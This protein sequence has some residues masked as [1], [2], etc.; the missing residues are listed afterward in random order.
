MSSARTVVLCIDR[1]IVREGVQTLLDA[2]PD[3][4]VVDATDNGMNAIMIVRKLA[5][6]VLVTGVG[7]GAMTGLELMLRIAGERLDTPPAVLMYGTIDDD[8]LL[9]RVLCSGAKGVLADDA[10]PEEMVLAVRLAARG[11]AILGPGAAE[12]V[13]S[14]HRHRNDADV[15]VLAPVDDLLTPREREILV[16]TAR[17]LSIEDIATRL[18]IGIATVRTHLYRLR[19]KLQARDRAQLVTLAFQS[20]LI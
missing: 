5:P 17:G 12:R 2:E 20:G 19:C 7:A 18:Y 9:S 4:D 10:S 1:P 8:T 15:A 3:I 14:W 16:L 6:D 13:L 11:K